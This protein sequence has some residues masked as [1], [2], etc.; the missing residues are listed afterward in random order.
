M[1]RFLRTFRDHLKEHGGSDD[2]DTVWSLLRRFKIL[3]FDFSTQGSASE[4]LARERAAAALEG[5]EAHRASNLWKELVE[6]A[7]AT[8]SVGGECTRE[9]LIEVLRRQHYRFAGTRRFASLSVPVSRDPEDDYVFACAVAAAAKAM[10]EQGVR[11]HV[12]KP[13]LRRRRVEFARPPAT[14]KHSTKPPTTMSVFQV[15]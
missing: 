1:P 8:A 4:E 12:R 9:D 10:S 6:L 2:D 3:T 15:S 14:T 11:L 5:D 13:I 7:I